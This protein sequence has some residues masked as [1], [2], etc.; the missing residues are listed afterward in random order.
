MTLR[1]NQEY[2]DDFRIDLR[3]RIEDADGDVVVLL[4][5]LRMDARANDRN[6]APAFKLS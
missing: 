6:I 2:A 4:A 3:N 5:I 1:H